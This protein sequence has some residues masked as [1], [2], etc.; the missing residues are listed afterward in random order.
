MSRKD[1]WNDT[2]KETGLPIRDLLIADLFDVSAVSF[3]AY[4]QT[5]AEVLQGKELSYNNLLD[6][7]SALNL[8]RGEAASARGGT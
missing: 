3:P 2:D 8:V 1:A 4:P 5:T 7:D 6:L